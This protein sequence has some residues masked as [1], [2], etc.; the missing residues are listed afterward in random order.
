MYRHL[1][2]IIL[3]VV[4]ID[5]LSQGNVLIPKEEKIDLPINK[6]GNVEL[7]AVFDETKIMPKDLKEL[8]IAEAKLLFDTADHYIVDTIGKSV[9]MFIMK[10]CYTFQLR[11]LS[12]QQVTSE[13]FITASLFFILQDKGYEI[14]VNNFYWMKNDGSTQS[15]SSLYSSFKKEKELKTK[16]KMYGVLKSAELLLTQTFHTAIIIVDDFIDIKS[17]GNIK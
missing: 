16:V 6:S 12:D 8:F 5:L 4:S 13:G 10:E 11:E 17:Q 7:G 1:I 14:L 9:E 15:I 2:L 3:T